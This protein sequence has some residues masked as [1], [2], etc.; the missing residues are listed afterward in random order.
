MRGIHGKRYHTVLIGNVLITTPSNT[1]E[2][3]MSTETH[4]KHS[5]DFFGLLPN[6][7]EAEGFVCYLQYV[8]NVAG[9]VNVEAGDVLMGDLEPLLVGI[10]DLRRENR[11]R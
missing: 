1:T 10:R 7:T 6:H 5:Q 11:Q 8:T 3:A 4:G 2:C 9:W